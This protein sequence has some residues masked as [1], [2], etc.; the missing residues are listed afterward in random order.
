LF[1]YTT[2]FR[3]HARGTGRGP[4]GVEM[5]TNAAHTAPDVAPEPR[6]AAD[7]GAVRRS[8]FETGVPVAI[9]VLLVVDLV[10]D[11]AGPPFVHATIEAVATAFAVMGAGRL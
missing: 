2:L 11:A 8:L 9:A 1:P 5:P 6:D 7:H 3:S 10:A 4:T